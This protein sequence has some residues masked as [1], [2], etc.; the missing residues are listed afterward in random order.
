MFRGF[1]WK[2][3]NAEKLSIVDYLLSSNES[4]SAE[5][6]LQLHEKLRILKSKYQK[7]CG[8]AYSSTR[9]GHVHRA[10]QRYHDDILRCLRVLSC[11]RRVPTEIWHGIFEHAV[12]SIEP[13]TAQG[14]MLGAISLVSRGWNAAA[15]SCPILWSNLPLIDIYPTASPEHS[16]LGPGPGILQRYL[17]RSGTH[18]ISFTFHYWRNIYSEI[19]AHNTVA[20]TCLRVLAAVSH[21]WDVAEFRATKV[22]LNA[23]SDRAQ[24]R[25]LPLHLLSKF[26]FEMKAV[27]P[28]PS[29][30]KLKVDLFFH[31]PNLRHVVFDVLGAWGTSNTCYI[32]G[33]IDLRLPWTQLETFEGFF[34]RDTA[35][36]QLLSKGK[37]LKVLM[38]TSKKSN[39]L[40]LVI[41]APQRLTR[42]SL[43]FGDGLPGGTFLAHMGCLT[44]P[45]LKE[46]EIHWRRG[47]NVDLYA[48]IL[49]LVQRSGCSLERL[50]VDDRLDY[51]SNNQLERFRDLLYHCATLTHLDIGYLDAQGLDSF[52]PDYDNFGNPP[53]PNLRVLSLRYSRIVRLPIDPEPLLK[54]IHSRT[55]GLVGWQSRLEDI[56][57]WHCGAD[58]WRA[59]IARA[60]HQSGSMRPPHIPFDSTFLKIALEAKAGLLTFFPAREHYNKDESMDR[61]KIRRGCLPKLES[62][63]IWG[64]DTRILSVRR[65]PNPNLLRCRS[66][67]DASQWLGIPTLLNLIGLDKEGRP[68]PGETISADR[69]RAQNLLNK[70]KP[71]LLVDFRASP[72]R[73]CFIDECM[74]RVRFVASTTTYESDGAYVVKQ[75]IL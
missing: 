20:L 71:Y 60:G 22:I 45:A 31:A 12:L 29:N 67:N 39:A 3:P 32:K 74:S 19:G 44:L 18:P 70:W 35:Y 51:D 7:A 11:I 17:E 6:E 46:L 9:N 41:A 33:I 75:Q 28:I 4:P 24:Y 73:W 34:K 63:D 61:H 30:S 69:Q 72:Y 38:Y 53:L 59:A 62:L 68:I 66:S 55:D 14:T 16:V 8:I 37:N 43:C 52:I 54:V 64:R 26:K 65:F 2:E 5:Q 40:P 25:R 42:L 57:V 10:G 56:Y 50:A 49:S 13:R 15:C 58:H 36:Q 1:R 23:L 21:R 47:T 48:A 27:E